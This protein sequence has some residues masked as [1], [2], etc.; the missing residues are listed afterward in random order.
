MVFLNNFLTAVTL[1]SALAA[2]SARATVRRLS[3]HHSRR[4]GRKRF[5]RV[6]IELCGNDFLARW[7]G[8]LSGI[9]KKLGIEI[10]NSSGLGMACW[11]GISFAIGN[12]LFELCRRP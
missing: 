1:V 9:K 5:P 11:I 7:A 6:G 3:A 4:T 2:L 10:G 12:F 8:S